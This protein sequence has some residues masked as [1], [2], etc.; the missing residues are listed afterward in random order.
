MSNLEDHMREQD[1]ITDACEALT[2]SDGNKEFAF[3]VK[4]FATIRVRAKNVG[5]AR[6]LLR[7]NIDCASANFG[8]WPNG[9][10]IIAEASI[11]DDHPELI[12]IDGD[13]V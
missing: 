2:D 4:L 8:A 11:D 1:E 12:E 10:P 7:E 6:R 9:D 3:D 13:A 5:T